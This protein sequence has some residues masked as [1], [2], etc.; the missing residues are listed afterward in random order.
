MTWSY[1]T[2]ISTLLDSDIRTLQLIGILATSCQTATQHLLKTSLLK[3]AAAKLKGLQQ[4]PNTTSQKT[5]ETLF[6][7]F[8][9]VANIEI[10]KSWIGD[11]LLTELLS[12]CTKLDTQSTVSYTHKS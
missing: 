3:D 7:F 12:R 1:S 8:A 9:D 6:S 5:A 4:M 11:N 10:V 2:D